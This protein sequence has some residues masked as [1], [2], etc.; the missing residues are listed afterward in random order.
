[1]DSQGGLVQG[2]E[3]D[4]KPTN[5]STGFRLDGSLSENVEIPDSIEAGCR[6]LGSEQQNDDYCSASTIDLG[7]PEGGKSERSDFLG[8]LARKAVL[9]SKPILRS[10]QS[11]DEYPALLDSVTI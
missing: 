3:T 4:L 1:M 9:M 8:K 7:K 5:G 2:Y 6:P 11:K 10:C